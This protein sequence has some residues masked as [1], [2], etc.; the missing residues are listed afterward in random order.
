MLLKDKRIYC[1]LLVVLFSFIISGCSVTL[2]TRHRSDIEKIDALDGEI[3]ELNA[4]LETLQAQ[5]EDELSELESAKKLLEERLK[6][7]IDDRTVRLEMAEKGL[8]IVFLT[9]ILFD[10][11]KAV[12]K[13]DAF[14]ALDKVVTVLKENISDRNIGVEGYTD[15]DPIKY[16]GWKSNWELSTARA[17]SVLH[18]I[19]DTKGINPKRVSATGYGEYRPVASNDTAEG[20]REN[21]RVEIVVLPKDMAKI[22]A[23]MEK[24]TQRKQQIEK[25]L[26]RYKK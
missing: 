16:S 9:E 24:V 15:N 5:K 22:E 10:S 26:K 2:Q 20:K 19:V 11:G 21:R 13:S 14:S 25:Q 12:I 23:D 7:E 8:A 18:Y 3:Q 1:T 4:K 6:K 17:T